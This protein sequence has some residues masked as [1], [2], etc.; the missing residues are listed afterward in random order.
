MYVR[1]SARLKKSTKTPR[2]KFELE[3]FKWLTKAKAKFKYEAEKLAYILAR[4]Y[5]P[6]FILTTKSGKIYIE[7]KGYLRAADKSKM[8]AIKIAYPNLDIRFVFHPK[9]KT[10]DTK[11]A[12]RNG[13]P[14]AI[15]SI[16]ESW[17]DE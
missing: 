14:Y 10:V 3:L 7:A 6:D 4:H 15:G 16:P 17:L 5:I 2:N 13:F 11:W 9:C 1:N 8:K 12:E